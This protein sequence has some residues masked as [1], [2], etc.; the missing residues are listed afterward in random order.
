MVR[1]QALSKKRLF[2]NFNIFVK[3]LLPSPS[4]DKP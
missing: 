1:P 4:N 3:F 2:N